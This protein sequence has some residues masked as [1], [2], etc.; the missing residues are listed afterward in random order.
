MSTYAGYGV[1]GATYGTEGWGVFGDAVPTTGTNYGVYGR[2]YSTAG[3]G[4]AGVA[5]AT[6]GLAYGVQGIS[7]ST[8]GR[9]VYGY[10][11]STTG[12]NYGIFGKTDSPDGYGGY[13]WGNVIVTDQLQLF[14]YDASGTPG[15]GSLEIGSSLRLDGNE[16][17]TNTDETLYF[18]HDNNGDLRID[19]TTLVVDASENRV[20]IRNAS[21][22]YP[23]DV[24]GAAH[25]SSFPTSSDERLKTDVHR[26]TNVLDRLERIRGVSFQW[27]ELYESMGRSTGHREIGVI[28]QEVEAE[29]PELVTRWGDEEYR[30]VDYGRLTGILIEAIRELRGE[31]DELRGETSTISESNRTLMRRIR[32]VEHTIGPLAG[33]STRTEE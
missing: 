22:A 17:I 23:L 1:F 13:F 11:A 25:A 14:N 10:A 15:T 8:Q 29:F 5:T 26:I 16:I 32:V 30:A 9:G 20:G 21:P 24:S 4:V 18:Q 28:A 7:Y 31:L 2:S 33:Q 12:I 19:N 3:F 27:N 6:A